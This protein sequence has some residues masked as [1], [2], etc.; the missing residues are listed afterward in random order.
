MATVAVLM[1]R[2]TDLA[3]RRC[4]ACRPGTPPLDDDAIQRL[5]TEVPEWEVVRPA[6]APARL[7]RALKFATFADALAFANRVGALA[8]AEDHHPELHV[9]WGRLGIETWTHS[10]GGLSENDFILA[11]KI[12]RAS[13]KP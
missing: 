10:V 1:E 2:M 8:D 13:G 11:A 6:G 7:R 9:S 3:D 12:D 5:L 4:A